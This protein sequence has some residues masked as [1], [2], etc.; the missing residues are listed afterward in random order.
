LEAT[1]NSFDFGLS[2]SL[3]WP[4]WPDRPTGLTISSGE[5][6][7]L[8]MLAKALTG[9]PLVGRRSCRHIKLPLRV[10]AGRMSLDSASYKGLSP[11]DILLPTE[12]P[13]QNGQLSLEYPGLGSIFLQAEGGRAK[14]LTWTGA[15]KESSVNNENNDISGTGSAEEKEPV[16]KDNPTAPLVNPAELEL[17]LNFELGHQTLTLAEL[18]ALA[19][20]FVFPLTVDPLGPVS[21][22]CHGQ[23]VAMGRLVNLGDSLG[24]QIIRLGTNS[25]HV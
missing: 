15:R 9:S 5:L 3:S 20:G 6:K 22:T 19:P 1:D 21:V 13:A 18:E 12:Y 16:R 17:P 8:P 14:V 25:E 10:I 2:F 4:A 23:T 7:N 24:V 11:A